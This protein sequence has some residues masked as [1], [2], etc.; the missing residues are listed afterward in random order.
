MLMY[1]LLKPGSPTIIFLVLGLLL[2]ITLSSTPLTVDSIEGR[3]FLHDQSKLLHEKYIQYA[4]R[5]CLN[6]KFYSFQQ[7]ILL[8]STVQEP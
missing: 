2:Q 7:F 3:T 4:S 1:F 5:V 8:Q 6:D